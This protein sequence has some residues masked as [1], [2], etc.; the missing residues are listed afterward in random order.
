MSIV[1]SWSV[2]IFWLKNESKKG[3]THKLTFFLL[4]K[5]D[6]KP[7]SCAITSGHGREQYGTRVSY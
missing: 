2:E 4:I 3:D 6:D 1:Q 5:E 7:Y